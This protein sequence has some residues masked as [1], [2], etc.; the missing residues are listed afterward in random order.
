MMKPSSPSIEKSPPTN[1]QSN[2]RT[3]HVMSERKAKAR[4]EKKRA[5]GDNERRATSRRNEYRQERT[6]YFLTNRIPTNTSVQTHPTA[7]TQR[8]PAR[9]APSPP[10]RRQPS[11]QMRRCCHRWRQ[12]CWTRTRPARCPSPSQWPHPGQSHCRSETHPRRQRPTA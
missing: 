9:P 10:S 7:R 8:A 1:C 2:H 11:C 4:P 6:D 3:H 5:T 12:P